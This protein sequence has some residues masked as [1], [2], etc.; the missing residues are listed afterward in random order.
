LRV[1][2]FG[3]TA[4]WGFLVGASPI[5]ELKDAEI[6][7]AGA[8]TALGATRQAKSHVKCCIS[9]G[10]NIETVSAMIEAA[11]KIAVWNRK[12]ISDEIDV[13]QLAEERK[14]NLAEAGQ[15]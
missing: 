6:L 12:P 3:R 10:N 13:K 2:Y 1:A 14:Q 4:I 15:K 8:I 7:V 11:R 5:F 9:V